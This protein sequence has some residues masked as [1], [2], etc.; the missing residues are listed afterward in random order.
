MIWSVRW[1]VL[2]WTALAIGAVAAVGLGVDI[3]VAGPD[4]ASVLAGIVVGFCE[5]VGAVL[6]MITWSGERRS[7]DASVR[8]VSAPASDSGGTKPATGKYVVDAR[9]A[10]GVQVGDGNV[11]HVDARPVPAPR[12][13]ERS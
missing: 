7:A 6:A 4:K 10:A 5:L 2:S 13:V 1:R 8:D 3:A 11:Q 12:R 9:G